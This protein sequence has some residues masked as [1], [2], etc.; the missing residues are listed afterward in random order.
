MIPIRDSVRSRTRPVVNYVLIA[1][2][3]AVFLLEVGLGDAG[4]DRLF[5]V[6]A[7][8]PFEVVSGREVP[9]DL[10]PAIAEYRRLL[11]HWYG[12]GADADLTWI[13]I[14]GSEGFREYLRQ[15][16]GVAPDEA[17][18]FPRLPLWER[19]MPLFTC[20]FLHG[21]WLHL[22]GNMWFLY[23]F[24]DN[25][26]DRLGHARFAVFYLA[27]GLGGGIAHVL[28]DPASPIPTVG[29]SG[30][31]AGVMGAYLLMY[32][33][34]RVLTLVPIWLFF[35]FL[36][37]PAWVFLGI[38]M[39]LQVF[40]GVAAVSAAAEAG[41]VAWFAHVGGFVVG[42]AWVFLVPKARADDSWVERYRPR[43]RGW[44]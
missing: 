31:I 30:A 29:A 23:V 35:T 38:W 42:A 17:L 26:E 9:A 39:L 1:V 8:T 21:G 3:C 24:G 36:E 19:L 22:I 44:E 12:A 15:A 37:I 40:Q 4:T 32:P 13:D 28:T 6:F 2:N 27:C 10:V 41:G 18:A 20:L 11:Q 25:V 14:A 7:L 5:G 34:A 43:M 33:H 16:H